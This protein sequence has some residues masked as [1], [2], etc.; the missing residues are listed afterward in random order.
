MINHD[1]L[2]QYFRDNHATKVFF[3]RLSLTN[4]NP[5][6]MYLY[7]TTKELQNFKESF[8]IY[9]PIYIKNEDNL[10]TMDFKGDIKAKLE[11]Y[12]KRIWNESKVMAHRSTNVNGIY[13]ELFL[14]I[15]LRIVSNINLL[16]SYA[17]I[18]SFNSNSESKGIDSIG[19]K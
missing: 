13:G 16:I 12:S 14:D 8:N 1:L 9:L 11:I 15:Y 2:T 6:I 10:E 7:D 5:G 17:S 4:G 18:R 3:T 19:Y